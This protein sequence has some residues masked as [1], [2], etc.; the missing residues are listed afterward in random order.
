[1]HLE[2]TIAFILAG[3]K[4][5]SLD[6]LSQKRAK[7]A[8]PF[9]AIYR[10]IDFALTNMFHSGI[11]NVGV[12]TQYR[13][14]SLMDHIAEGEAWDFHGW[15]RN[16][17]IFPPY[18]RQQGS[19]WYKGTADAVYQNLNFVYDHNPKYILI[20]SGDHIYNIDY[21][22]VLK[23]HNSKNA[24]ITIVTKTLENVSP[25]RFGMLE[26]DNN[27]KI[28]AYE[29]KQEKIISKTISLGIYI[30][31]TDILIPLL[32][33]DVL[34][35]SSH[36][37]GKEIIKPNLFKYNIFAY[38]FDDPWFYLG[39]IREY[40][41]ANM[42]LLKPNPTIKLKEWGITTN[43][44]DGN[45]A[46]L[47]PT[48][49][50]GIGSA[51]NSIIANGCFIEGKVENSIL[52]PGVIVKRD[53]IVSNSILMNN[54]IVNRRTRL[55]E[56]VADK[57]VHFGVNVIAGEG[58]KI[59]NKKYPEYFSS[60]ISVMAKGIIISDNS[61]IG[62]NCLFFASTESSTDYFPSGSTV[63]IKT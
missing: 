57:D 1:M 11:K 17:L 25:G 6:I 49:F 13:P 34:K 37:I 27:S 43:L 55:N 23:W 10:V 29:E 56:I 22:K 60:G 14:E 24:D 44:I 21:G 54:V 8:I 41:Q 30:F 62:K 33:Q 16:I 20:V 31:N 35:V 9:G 26:I 15:N 42:E 63:E 5:P 7:A 19:D 48:R 39:T 45:I 46:N 18:K 53:A 38:N 61:K 52:F 50:R 40:W 32:K 36:D 58:E 47:P 59:P 51:T 4:K 2:N 12:L 3:G 28:I